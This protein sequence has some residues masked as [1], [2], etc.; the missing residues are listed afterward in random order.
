[1]ASYMDMVTVLMC[2]F[3][4]LFSMSTVDQ[5]K[6]EKLKSSLATGFGETESE[7]VDTAEGLVVPKE[8]VGEE[9]ETISELEHARL[10]VDDLTGLRDGLQSVLDSKGLGNTVRFTTSEAGLTMRMVNSE[11]FFGPDSAELRDQA[12]QVLAESAPLLSSSGRDISVE[13]HTAAQ[14]GNEALRDWELSS[15]RAVNVVRY[16]IEKGGITPN[17]IEG[18][19]YAGYRPILE[20]YSPEAMQANR[21][22][23]LVVHSDESDSVRAHIPEVIA[24]EESGG[25]KKAAGEKAEEKKGH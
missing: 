24:E 1:M 6:Y 18:T 3:I 11:A 7:T 12:I 5:E 21:R 17:K 9:S 15:E 25:E 20:G 23:D 14:P 13:G 4:V 2:L 19:G 22:V 8:N 16:M 10:E